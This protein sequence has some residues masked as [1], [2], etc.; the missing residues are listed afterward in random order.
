MKILKVSFQN[1]HSIAKC[2]LDFTVE[3]L[4][5]AG[6]F[7]ITG[8]TGAGKSTI[9]DA[10]TLAL[11]GRIFRHK[12]GANLIMSRG[13]GYAEA[14]VVFEGEGGA[15]FHAQW[16]DRRA[17]D[18]AEGTLQGAKMT[19][20]D[21]KENI[22][23]SGISRAKAVIIEKAG[24]DF[25]QFTRSVMLCQG[26]FK[27]FLEADRNDRASLLERLTS[28]E[29]YSKLSVLAFQKFKEEEVKYT[30][31]QNQHKGLALLTEEDLAELHK[32]SNE[33]KLQIQTIEKEEARAI[34][35]IDWF[36]KVRA[37]EE[38]IDQ[39]KKNIAQ[40]KVAETGFEP[41]KQL[42]VQ[43]KKAVAFKSELDSKTSLGNKLNTLS[44][45][46]EALTNQL[47][48]LEL[49]VSVCQD[50]QL[51]T[52]TALED[53]QQRWL[54]A[55]PKLQLAENL[56][57]LIEAD[58]T[59]LANE[60]SS[61]NLILT[62]LEQQQR[63]FEETNSLLTSIQTAV[64]AHSKWLFDNA[65]DKDLPVV[66][67]EIESLGNQHQEVETA[68]VSTEKELKAL[69]E[70][71][72]ISLEKQANAEKEIELETAN[73]QTVN[74][75]LVELEQQIKDCI[76]NTSIP[77][78]RTKQQAYPK[79]IVQL[80]QAL[81]EENQ[82]TSLKAMLKEEVQNLGLSKVKLEELQVTVEQ[83]EKNKSQSENTVTDKERLLV[84]SRLISKYEDDR[85]KLVADE[86]C[87][88]CGS[89][90]HPYV[91]H[92]VQPTVNEDE[93]A[94]EKAKG[95][96]Q[97][98]VKQL[99]LAIQE[100]TKL[101]EQINNKEAFLLREQENLNRLNKAVNDVIAQNGSSAF[102]K[103]SIIETHTFLQNELVSVQSK[104][105][106][107][108]HLELKINTQKQKSIAI[109]ERISTAN[110]S[111]VLAQ[112]QID[113][114]KSN[115]SKAQ[116][117]LADFQVKLGLIR[118]ALTQKLTPFGVDY[119]N[120]V[121]A[122]LSQRS[123]AFNEKQQVLE[124][125]QAKVQDLN[126]KLAGIKASITASEAEKLGKQ[127]NLTSSRKLIDD[128]ITKRGEVLDWKFNVA[129]SRSRYK[130]QI[131]QANAN[132]E[133]SNTALI[134]AELN[135]GK[136][137][138]SLANLLEQIQKENLALTQVTEV[139][140]NSIN[141]L[142]FSSI[143]VMALAILSQI[144]VNEI[145][146]EAAA[147]SKSLT[148]SEALFKKSEEELD[149]LVLQ[150]MG[151]IV[152]D[153]LIIEASQYKETIKQLSENLGDISA[154]LTANEKVENSAKQILQEIEKQ[155]AIKQRWSQ[156]NELIGSADGKKFKAIAQEFT[157]EY[158]VAL[159]NNYLQNISDRYML[160]PKPDLQLS[161]ADAYQSGSERSVSTLSGGES[162]LVSLSL[163]LGL[164]DMA[165]NRTHIGSLFIDEGF[166]TLDPETLDIAISAL[167]NLQHS[168]N[169][170]I[171]IIS[172]VEALKE[173]ITTQIEV[174]KGK[175]GR[176]YIKPFELS[177]M[178]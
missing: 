171:G 69:D 59:R 72:A 111:L 100:H 141:N 44:S 113:A 143:E 163:A 159:A 79:T 125:E 129:D 10:I 26:A 154:Q 103:G 30:N 36:N 94:L 89:T 65:I 93:A 160:I 87:Y 106:Q 90:E 67:A 98:T 96:L 3:P 83:L 9:L 120:G 75:E 81:K 107:F 13:A 122:I 155:F 175:S 32:I 114:T 20:A 109:G 173:R 52:K 112:Q 151:E 78:L 61:F 14:N 165:G 92:Q 39:A 42:L 131:Q 172:H 1:I 121:S 158:L 53:L 15:V 174:V 86:A 27:Q 71:L 146:T 148:E 48:A 126:A 156:L 17:R 105:V 37:I 169:K 130:E 12:D 97:E 35:A 153:D 45:E 2:D 99:N 49:E 162:F 133:A 118:T 145:E 29:I 117:H 167:E 54:A 21:D 152:I 25:E 85:T 127:E 138:T 11:Y 68:I 38:K 134:D 115:I 88:L 73:K 28:S 23:E 157:L 51:K 62:N 46:K 142:N 102:W 91:D 34:S 77:E 74:S 139:L 64:N 82:A 95:T 33:I 80:E 161:I 43:H 132:A 41:K 76:G 4:A 55:E 63:T 136:Q 57:S 16:S 166:G 58:K 70:S 135:L 168:R 128:N 84:Q 176:S 24:L 8:P 31:L 170:S 150:E 6:L 40:A 108:E 66:L 56:D 124:Q 18:R 137:R 147:I 60:E 116:A 22:I 140:T 104:V 47:Q 164:S 149:D 101:Q 144:Q 110:T 50:N 177:V 19:I 7:A 5:S 119:S 123:K 178:A